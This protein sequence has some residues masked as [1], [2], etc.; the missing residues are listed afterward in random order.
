MK[1]CVMDPVPQVSDF[2]TAVSENEHL[3]QKTGTLFYFNVPAVLGVE[4]LFVTSPSINLY[5]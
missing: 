1:I 5:Q 2:D 4:Q 3:I